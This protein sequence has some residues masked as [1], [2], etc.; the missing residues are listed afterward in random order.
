MYQ[1]VQPYHLNKIAYLYLCEST[2]QQ[3][4]GHQESLRVP[5]RLKDK[6]EEIGF[7]DR[8][9]VID[10][11]LRKSAVGYMEREGFK[12]IIT[13]SCHERAGAMA[14]WEASDLACSHFEWQNLIR[15]CKVS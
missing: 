9:E 8:I 13:N 2:P 4:I 5:F 10:N 11:D 6:L 12:S 3:L 7:G 1:K 15:F 14:A